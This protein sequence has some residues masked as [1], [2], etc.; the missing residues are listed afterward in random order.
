VEYL[1]K[2]KHWDRNHNSWEP[3][4]NILDTTLIESYKKE[5]K[6][7]SRRTL[8]PK[9]CQNDDFSSIKNDIIDK[10]EE[11][12]EDEE[13]KRIDS[14]PIDYWYPP[15]CEEQTKMAITDITSDNVTI[16]FRELI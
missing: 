15:M 8:S 2:W 3:E 7:I 14:T 16:T 13:E 5:N 10:Q 6:S 9:K 1:V 4:G 11:Q 12:L